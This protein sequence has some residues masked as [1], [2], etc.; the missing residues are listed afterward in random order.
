[1]RSRLIII[2]LLAVATIAAAGGVWFFVQQSRDRHIA[3]EL[4]EANRDLAENRPNS[5]SERLNQLLA[6]R[7]GRS[8]LLL[9][10]GQSELARGKTE[11]ALAALSQIPNGSAEIGTASAL[12]SR[13]EIKEGMLDEAET[14]L[15]ATLNDPANLGCPTLPET[16]DALVRLLRS[17]GRFA[18]GRRVYLDGA[19]EWADPVKGLKGLYRLDVDPIPTEGLSTYLENANKRRPDDDRA[20]LGLAALETRLGRFDEADKWL[21]ACLAKRPED[22][23]VWA[24]RLHW[25]KEADRSAELLEAARHLPADVRLAEEIRVFFA[26]RQGDRD[27]EARALET[28]NKLDSGQPTIL[29]RLAE[30]AAESGKSAEAAAYRTK[31]VELNSAREAYQTLLASTPVLKN[32]EELGKLA[33]KLGRGFEA[34]G[35]ATLSKDSNAKLAPPAPSKSTGTLAD[36]LTDVS[37]GSFVATKSPLKPAD[38]VEFRD[39]AEAAGLR[40]IH[41][42]GAS[43]DASRL[44]PPVSASGGVG[45]IDYDGDGLLDVYCVQ[46]GPFPQGPSSGAGDRLFRNK[47]DG[48]FEDVSIASK[49]ASLTQGYGHGVAVA[50]YDNDGKPDL[51]LTRWR[52]YIQLHNQGD[53]TFADATSSATLQGDRD[54]PTSAGFA[55]LD[56]DGDLDLYVCHYFEWDENDTRT[57]ADPKNPGAYRCTPLAFRARQDHLFRNDNGRF[58]D[59]SKESGIAAIDTGGRGLGV[60]LADLDGDHRTDIFV[61]N[62]MSANYFLHNLGDLKFEEIGLAAGLAANGSGGFQAGMGTACGDFDG[63]GRPDI[64]VTNFFGESTSY[65]HNLRDGVFADNTAAIAL[66]GISRDLLG[67]GVALPDVDNDGKLDFLSVNGH[68]HDGRPQFPFLMPIQ[69]ALQGNDGKL[70]QA[71]GKVFEAEH[72][73]RGLAIGDLDNDGK[74]DAVVLSQNESLVYLH[75]VSRRSGHFVTLGLAGVESNRDGVGAEIVVETGKTRRYFARFGG[76]SYQSASDPRIHVGLGD[77]AEINAVEIRWPSGNTSRYDHLKGDAGYLVREGAAVLEPLPGFISSSKRND[78]QRNP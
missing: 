68:I 66:S 15:S 21:K 13:I 37:A 59:I 74:M 7:P 30:L 35:W 33:A 11:K 28:Q 57:C 19:G 61:A 54:W 24:E 52:S 44:I 16:R 14:Q 20:W 1:M 29:N 3:A 49:I 32:A 31:A 76:G 26:A 34:D 48:T 47:G 65:F 70:R 23:A 25:A 39:D 43:T 60:V 42:N 18:E 63:D 5:A 41:E 46:S 72:M 17:E 27:A 36:L 77:A 78:T 38:I 64:F 8:D 56:N 73:G 40:F 75:N 58:V 69:L 45:L 51:F 6:I 67:F 10:L 12:R 4:V 22:Q 53:G 71:A 62:D 2:A 55:D 50:D 9:L